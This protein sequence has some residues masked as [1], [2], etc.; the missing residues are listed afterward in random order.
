[1]RALLRS[2]RESTFKDVLYWV[3]HEHL[4]F[5]HRIVGRGVP[6]PEGFSIS[7]STKCKAKKEKELFNNFL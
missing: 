6:I 5:T 4:G 3:L 7:Q 1:V 2:G